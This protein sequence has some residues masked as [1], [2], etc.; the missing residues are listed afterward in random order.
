[1]AAM[2]SAATVSAQDANPVKVK[3]L[4]T[5]MPYNVMGISA[6]GKFIC[7]TKQEMLA[8]RYDLEHDTLEV[9]WADDD[10]YS[11]VAY[12]VMDDGTVVGSD[13]Y[14][15]FALWQPN[16]DEWKP[17]ETTNGN[18]GEG[19]AFQCSGDGK[20]LAGFTSGEKSDEQP[21]TLKPTLWVRQADGKYEEQYLPTPPED[22]VGLKPQWCRPNCVSQDGKVI[23]AGLV[24]NNGTH[25]VH[26]LY[27]QNEDGTWSYD[28][29]TFAKITYTSKF[30]EIWNSQPDFD[31]YVTEKYNYGNMD[32]KK[33]LA[34]IEEYEAAMEEWN[35]KLDAEGYTGSDFVAQPTLS[36]NGK[37]VL[38]AC[39]D[40]A[41][42]GTYDC[43][44]IYDVVNKVYTPVHSL[45]GHVVGGITNDGDIVTYG[46]GK[47]GSVPFITMHDNLNEPIAVDEMLLNEY[48]VSLHD[49]LPATTTGCDNPWVSGDGKVITTR[50]H[51]TETVANDDGTTT[52]SAITEIY[53]IVMKD[54]ASAIRNVLSTP[55]SEGINVVDGVVTLS[56]KA[57]NISVYGVSGRLV[58][59]AANASTLDASSIGRG[60][61]LVKAN[62]GGKTLTT[63]FIK[64]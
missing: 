54:L 41:E 23:S 38:G 4:K 27:T 3:I 59:S 37:W 52:E 16:S 2:F 15:N 11:V 13:K 49:S 24:D 30:K 8:Y 63:K 32:Y 44:A 25:Y 39:V 9:A 53:C 12:D 10:N 21:W 28:W 18:V 34:Q 42:D 5:E 26:C 33:Y 31:A 45:A 64:K 19:S 62:V 46:E 43:P 50:A 6:N 60:V 47:Q 20:F 61:Y 40:A 7:G 14:G 1:M 56:S 58:A 29:E 17:V 22:L 48:G 35:K 55:T 36:D 51:Y 57:K